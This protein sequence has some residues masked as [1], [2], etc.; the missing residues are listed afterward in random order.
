M[1]QGQLP[2][3]AVPFEWLDWGDF[4]YEL[5]PDGSPDEDRNWQKDQYHRSRD[6]NAYREYDGDVQTYAELKK[7]DPWMLVAFDAENS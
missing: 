4:F 6:T 2:E 1:K 7:F 5:R 3:N